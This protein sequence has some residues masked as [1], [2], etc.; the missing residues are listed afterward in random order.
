MDILVLPI[1]VVLNT[2][3]V[4][5]PLITAEPGAKMLL[6]FVARALYPPLFLPEHLFLFLLTTLVV[7]LQD[8][9]VQVINAVLNTGGVVL[10]LTIVKPDV[11]ALLDPVELYHLS[12]LAT[13]LRLQQ[14]LS[15][16]V[17]FSL[18]LLI[19]PVD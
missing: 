9:C 14:H 3:G 16:V 7:K 1:N 4:G 8:T 10:L 15:P 11:K 19:I 18:T 2:D 5:P 6:E 13:P 12:S 17:W